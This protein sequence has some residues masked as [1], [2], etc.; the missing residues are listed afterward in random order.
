MAQLA[1]FILLLPQNPYQNIQILF[2]FNSEKMG[3]SFTSCYRSLQELNSLFRCEPHS[4]VDPN[5]GDRFKLTLLSLQKCL[6][7]TGKIRD[8]MR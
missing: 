5:T 3:K 4:L 6:V 7:A 1:G 8:A 2:Q